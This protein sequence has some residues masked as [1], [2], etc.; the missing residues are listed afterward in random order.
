MS[1]RTSP[2]VSANLDGLHRG[3]VARAWSRVF[4]AG[5]D[6]MNQAAENGGIAQLRE[7][8][9]S[10]ASGDVLEV[11]AG[12]GANVP[13]YPRD[14]RSLTLT[15]PDA[16]M[17]DRLVDRLAG[18]DREASV[19]AAPA[20][21][22]PMVKQSVDTVVVTYVLCSVNLPLALAEIRRVLRPEGQ[23]LFVEHVRSSSSRQARRQDWLNP[24]WRAVACGCNC[25]RDTEEALRA[26]GFVLSELSHGGVDQ[27]LALVRP[28]IWGRALQENAK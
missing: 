23:L 24:V 9:L 27:E 16:A 26:G 21:A 2:R 19:L 25:N 3:P 20:E 17:R 1:I 14:L 28:T 8:L 18:D 12:T 7:E 22:L 4:A 15:E 6:T 10:R 13:Y 11:G 5:Y